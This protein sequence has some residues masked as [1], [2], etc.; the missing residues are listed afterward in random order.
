MFSEDPGDVLFW[1]GVCGVEARGYS[2]WLSAKEKWSAPPIMIWSKSSTSIEA[3]AVCSFLV[4]ARSLE[5]G[6]VRPLGWL[7][8]MRI[9]AE[10]SS[11]TRVITSLGKIAEDV[12]EPSKSTSVDK[13]WCCPLRKQATK[14]SFLLASEK[15][16][17]K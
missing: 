14:H 13:T 5:E 2:K 15:S 6:V 11:I 3:R 8:A 17:L 7:C 12:R 16:A 4:T 1:S 10:P 9:A